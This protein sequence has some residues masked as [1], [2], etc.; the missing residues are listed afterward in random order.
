MREIKE[1]VREKD[2]EGGRERDQMQLEKYTYDVSVYTLSS[3]ATT[4]LV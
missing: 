1:R 2:E 3:E 4:V